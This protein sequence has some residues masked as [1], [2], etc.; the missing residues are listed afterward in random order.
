MSNRIVARQI[1]EK[2][3]SRRNQESQ[4]EGMLKEAYEAGVEDGEG[5]GEE[6]DLNIQEL[7]KRYGKEKRKRT[8]LGLLGLQTDKDTYIAPGVD[9][10]GN[11][12][13]ESYFKPNWKARGLQV[14]T[15]GPDPFNRFPGVHQDPY[16]TMYS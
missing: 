1:M 8:I 5:G 12:M 10:L 7:V 4:L 13:D 16:G 11:L 3:A 14:R 9:I 15:K 2:V 6:N